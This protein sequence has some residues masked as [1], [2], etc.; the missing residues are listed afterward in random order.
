MLK[1]EWVTL[2]LEVDETTVNELQRTRNVATF[3]QLFQKCNKTVRRLDL[4]IMMPSRKRIS[5]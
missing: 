1:T 5:A 3:Q 2:R 4:E